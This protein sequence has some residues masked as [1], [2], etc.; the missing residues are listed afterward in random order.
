M[1]LNRL[2]EE[3]GP[4]NPSLTYFPDLPDQ[5]PDFT[6]GPGGPVKPDHDADAGGAGDAGERNRETGKQSELGQG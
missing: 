4:V 3:P 5:V 2:W 1:I 6:G